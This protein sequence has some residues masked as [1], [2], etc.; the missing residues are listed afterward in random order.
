MSRPLRADARERGGGGRS[1]YREFRVCGAASP[2]AVCTWQAVAGW[3]RPLRLL[4]DGCADLVWDGGGLWFAPAQAAAVREFVAG[5]ARNAG[6]RLRPGAAGAFIGAPAE[7]LPDARTRLSDL[8]GA[9][10]AHA[11]TWVAEA[12]DLPRA[13]GRLEALAVAR[14]RRVRP[15]AAV[16]DACRRLRRPDADLGAIT[17]AVGL[18]PRELR[19]RFS[20]HVGYGPKTLQRILRLD[21]TLRRLAAP[22]DHRLA[23]LAAE[24]GYA[25]QAHFTRECRE[26]TGSTPRQLQGRL[27]E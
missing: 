17:Q 18:T 16:L 27:R 24:A 21:G 1:S 9:A 22:G 15:D 12:A 25:D 23:A 7:T 8:W 6:L 19:R 14:A 10:G 26:L 20:A 13:R 2:L 5:D 4:P 11:E 3:S